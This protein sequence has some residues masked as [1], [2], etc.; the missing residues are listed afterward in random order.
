LF[1][2]YIK[3]Q[4]K[5]KS[6]H[7]PR[8]RRPKTIRKSRKRRRSKKT[9]RV[10]R[11]PS[12]ISHSSRDTEK[13]HIPILSRKLRTTSKSSILRLQHFAVLKK[14]IPDLLFQFTG[15]FNKML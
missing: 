13:D 8:K 14:V 5:I 11:L 7:Q 1:K 3:W 4:K 9:T 15:N 6:T 2:K 12:K 10:D